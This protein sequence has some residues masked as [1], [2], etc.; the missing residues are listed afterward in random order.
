M[1]YSVT[2]REFI[3]QLQDIAS[4]QG[5]ELKVK[6]VTPEPYREIVDPKLTIN[7]ENGT[8]FVAIN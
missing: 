7:F 2:L 1:D 4:K 8:N 6:V 3:K 5:D